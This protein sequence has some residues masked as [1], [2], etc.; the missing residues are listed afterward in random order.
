MKTKISP[1]LVPFLFILMLFS[2][3]NENKN[4]EYNFDAINNRVWIGE[5][6]WTVPLEDWRVNNGRI[7]YL[8]EGQQ[9]TFTLLTSVLN[10]SEASFEISLDLGLIEKGKN[11]GSVGLTIG[12]EALE[13]FDIRAAIFFG[14]GMDM[15]INTAGYAF[16]EQQ[17]VDL[18]EGLDYNHL[19]LHVAANK[20]GNEVRFE[21]QDGSGK[22]LVQLAAT[23]EKPLKGI[24]QIVNNFRGGE[25]KNN[26]PK[27]WYDNIKIGG[28]KF[29]HQPQNQFGP[30]LW[31]MHTLSRNT[32]KLT[33]QLPPV[34]DADNQ[35]VELQLKEGENWVSAGKQNI[36]A[37]ARTATFR[38]EN[39]NSSI[40]KAY[41]VLYPHTN[42]FCEASTAEFTGTI[43]KDPVDKPLNLGALTC[44]FYT[45]FPY[46]PLVKNLTAK[47]PDM[48]YFSGDQI[49]ENNGGY[50]I[51]RAPED[52]AILSY[53]GKWYMFGWAFGDLM[54]DIPTVCTPDDHDV[55][56]GNIWGGGGIQKSE[57]MKETHDYTGFAQTV[58]M[59]NMVNRTQCAHL[60]D[61]F[62]PTPIGDGMSVWYTS[63]NYGRI[64]FAI[65]SDRI[66]KSGPENVSNWEGRRDH[67]KAPVSRNKLE[68]PGLQFLG[69]RQ[70][71]FL[72]QWV[73]DWNG[74]DMK[75]LLSQTV[76]AN[77]AT[78]HG[79]F[80]DY[81]YGDMDSGGWP[82]SGRDRAISIIRKGF[83]FQIAGDQHLPSLLQYGLDNFRD[84]GWCYCTPA[85]SITYSR[86]FRPDE[87][88]IPVKNRPEHGLPNTG[89]YEDSFGNLNYV[90]AI[91]NPGDF[92][93][94]PNRYEFET[95]RSAGF[96]M[97]YFN[98]VKR[99]I[100]MESWRFLADVANPDPN[101]Q[102]PG[103]PLTISQFENYGRKAEGWLPTIRVE[104]E[105]NP[106]IDVINEKT[107]EREYIVRISGNEFTP[108]VFS[109][110]L[111]KIKLSYPEKGIGKEINNIQ[112]NS[113][114][115][116]TEISVN[117]KQ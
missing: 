94:V 5:E 44:Q 107:G 76:F 27:F 1:L 99:T 61:P 21:V 46:S 70:E 51:K 75:V 97:V 89:E 7:E 68:K 85:I 111:Y 102:H 59:V 93:K 34:G 2:C 81:L 26:G 45:G 95:E 12:S 30:I 79:F 92:K 24:V 86:W 31:A 109:N 52:M 32:L 87:L 11:D 60:P 18:P 71:D 101:D 72:E 39:W 56:Q 43:R 9:A 15:G 4:R 67:I 90:Y 10:E 78:H 33:A 36:D 3:K 55:F 40:D 80:N 58:K 19:K 28:E 74:V 105:P 37:D 23:P 38:I 69:K 63:L 48:L 62:D 41:R 6:F 42:V 50:P 113:K 88:N 96:G 103:W 22:Q 106:V 66:F 100:T 53:L 82:K 110:D 114:Q 77:P 35:E 47:S 116:Q 108:K 29:L 115:G 91:G 14:N 65:V 49:Y 20:N 8:G 112:P 104:G 83:A 73:G 64:S 57:E 98:Q 54:R 84:A 17:T 117:T 13:E 25:S 16:L